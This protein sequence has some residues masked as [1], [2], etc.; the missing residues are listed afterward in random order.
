MTLLFFLF[1]LQIAYLL[2]R[3]TRHNNLG[4]TVDYQLLDDLQASQ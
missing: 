1:F 3:T 2:S 4:I